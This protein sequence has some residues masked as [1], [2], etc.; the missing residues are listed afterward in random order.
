MWSLV[1]LTRGLASPKGSY[2]LQGVPSAQAWYVGL[3]AYSAFAL[4]VML[5]RTQASVLREKWAKR[6]VLRLAWGDMR[7]APSHSDVHDN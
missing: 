6:V 1:W 2:R 7:P 5:A 3:P 4:I